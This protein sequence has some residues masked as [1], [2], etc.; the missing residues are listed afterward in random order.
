VSL[1]AQKLGTREKVSAA[2]LDQQWQR[3]LV[4]ARRA[5]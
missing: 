5:H 1:F 3:V 2:R 4:A